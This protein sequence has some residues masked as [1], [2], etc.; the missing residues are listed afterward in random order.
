VPRLLYDFVLNRC[1]AAAVRILT[2]EALDYRDWTIW[3]DLSSLQRDSCLNALDLFH[4]EIAYEAEK[5][6]KKL[7]AAHVT[8]LLRARAQEHHLLCTPMLHL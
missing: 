3:T 6:K 8:S 4:E 7:F 1:D 5:I 2:D